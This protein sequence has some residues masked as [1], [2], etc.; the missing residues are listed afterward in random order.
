MDMNEGG[1]GQV[2]GADIDVDS[3]LASIEQPQESIPMTN[4]PQS[5]ET[6]QA[7]PESKTQNELMYEFNSNGKQVRVGANDPRVTQ[8]LNQG[9]S[10]SQSVAALKQEQEQFKTERE[11]IQA[12]KD[13][14]EGVDQWVQQNPQVW[15][16]LMSEF[17][18]Q[19]PSEQQDPNNPLFQKIQALEQK[20]AG[21]EPVIQEFVSDKEKIKIEQQDKDLESQYQS[22]REKF[23][24]LD[25]SAPQA[26]GQSLEYHV[27]KFAN[28]NNIKNFEHAF[29]LY[30]HDHLV[31]RASEK[32]KE[33]LN[34][35]IQKK[36]KLGLL[37]KSSTPTQGIQKVQDVKSKNYND[38]E[39]EILKELN[40]R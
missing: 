32:A 35:D 24:D 5:Q 19:T 7:A 27:L 36:T 21:V 2:G 1:A 6:P 26:D 16:R 39:D 12:I 22:I 8:W 33:A 37:G 31:A 34:K 17:Q 11:Q 38:I 23:S 18:N 20:L 9:Y 14:Y 4:E 25:L 10:Y 30:N 15:Q 28:E 40:L 13:K 3:L 29:K